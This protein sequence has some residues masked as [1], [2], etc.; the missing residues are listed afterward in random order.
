MKPTATLTIA[1][2]ALTAVTAISAPV[3]FDWAHV[4]NAGNADDIHGAGYGGVDYAYRISK[5]EV[6]NSQYTTF[7]NAVDPAG[8]NSLGLYSANMASNYGGIENI[9]VTD[10]SRYV[11]KIGREQNPVTYVSFID[12]MRFTNW[13]HN[14]QGTGDTE[15]GAYAIDSGANE[16]RSTSARYWIPSE[17][18]W[19]KAAYHDAAAG[20][21]G[22]YFDYATGSD[23]IPVSD[24]PWDNPAAV[25]YRND[26]GI[27]NGWNDGY[28]VSGSNS[29]GANPLTDVGAYTSGA[30]P[31]GTFDQNG[32]VWEWNEAVVNSSFRGLRGGSWY[33]YSFDLRAVFRS[34][35]YPAYESSVIGFRVAM[36]PEPSAILVGALAMVG[37]LVWRR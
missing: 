28:A 24:Q 7:L 19:Y 31:Y 2:L 33:Y 8:A 37:M 10:G 27:S 11:V 20:T 36:V 34:D 29:V 13:L 25:N 14:G 26:D 6:T 12:A 32:N 5:H 16:L 30:S 22:V 35:F 15:T 23:T 9:G 18:E 4:G 3:T 1:I 21:A 17:D